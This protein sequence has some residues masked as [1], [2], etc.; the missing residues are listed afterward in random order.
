MSKSLLS[1]GNAIGS[2]AVRK[3][4]VFRDRTT[5]ALFPNSLLPFLVGPVREESAKSGRPA[6][7]YFRGA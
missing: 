5:N 4:R 6:S 3:K 2:T 1:N 7:P